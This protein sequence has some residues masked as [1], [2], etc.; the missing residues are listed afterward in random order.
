MKQ[1]HTLMFLSTAS[2]AASTS[3]SNGF[4]LYAPLPITKITVLKTVVILNSYSGRWQL[5]EKLLL[6]LAGACLLCYSPILHN[7]LC[8]QYERHQGFLQHHNSRTEETRRSLTL[9]SKSFAWKLL[10]SLTLTPVPE[11]LF[12]T[13]DCRRS[14]FLQREYGLH[15]NYAPIKGLLSTV[16]F[17][18]RP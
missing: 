15:H 6:D 14:T 7:I 16:L 3:G 4:I 10:T 13:R 2:S 18:R 1:G 5:C 12:W 9:V 11:S 8:W 17:S